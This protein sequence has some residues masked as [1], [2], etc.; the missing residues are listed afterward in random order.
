MANKRKRNELSLADKFEA[1]KLLDKKLWQVEIAKRLDCSQPAISKIAKNKEAIRADFLAN[2]NPDRI[3]HRSGKAADVEGALTEWFKHA[4]AR[5]IPLSGPIL[6]EKAKDLAKHL[7]YDDFNPS[8]GWLAR[9][10]QRNN[11][12]FKRM[13]GEKKDADTGAA[14]HWIE[15]TLPSSLESY[16]PETCIVTFDSLWSVT[17]G[18]N[19][20]SVD[21]SNPETY[22]VTFD[23]LWSVTIW[24]NLLGVDGYT[25]TQIGHQIH[26]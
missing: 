11:I 9:W 8:V 17:I 5:D 25:K 2:G 16:D 24:L 14:E 3:R 7:N 13:H 4:R 20:L 26:R 18:L 23:S 22:I 6:A 10:K 12:A 15:N 21:G 19:L 1:V